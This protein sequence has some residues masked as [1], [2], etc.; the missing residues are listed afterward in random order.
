MS[1]LHKPAPP[2]MKVADGS[3]C[4]PMPP[5]DGWTLAEALTDHLCPLE[6]LIAER[7][8]AMLERALRDFS[9]VTYDFDPA[10]RRTGPWLRDCLFRALRERSDLELTGHDLTKGVSVPRTRIPHS[11]IRAAAFTEG[12][13]PAQRGLTIAFRADKCIDLYYDHHGFEAASEGSV[14]PAHERLV[15]VRIEQVRPERVEVAHPP[16][17]VISG[18]RPAGKPDYSASRCRGWFKVR[19]DGWPDSEPPPPL[20]ECLAAARAHFTGPI[21][22]DPFAAIR[23]R[24]VPADWNKS[25]PRS[26]RY[27]AS[28][29]WLTP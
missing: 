29:K 8:G 1:K 11:L 25:G 2:I 14:Y 16:E 19:V 4:E 22:R 21:A 15:A 27:S 20:K 9:K 23:R 26:P 3:A 28:K 7:G 13:R 12:H 10:S 6:Y 5:A 17:P 24:E 18:T